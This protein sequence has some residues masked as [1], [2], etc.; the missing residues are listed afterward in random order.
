VAKIN[1]KPGDTLGGDDVVVVIEWHGDQ[2]GGPGRPTPRSTESR[3]AQS[4][5]CL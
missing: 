3:T 4:E 1:V 5:W 2:R